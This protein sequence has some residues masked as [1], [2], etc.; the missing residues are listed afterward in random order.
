MRF[1]VLL[2]II[3]LALLLG[4]SEKETKRETISANANFKIQTLSEDGIL[5]MSPSGSHPITKYK[6][7]FNRTYFGYYSSN[8]NIKVQYF[9]NDNYTMSQPVVLWRNWGYNSAGNTLGD[10]HANPSI[11][12]LRQQK[13]E[14]AMHNGKLIV[15]SAE[16]GAAAEKRGRLQVK[17]G[18]SPESISKWEEAI[19]LRNTRATYARLLELSDGTIFLFCRLSR[20]APN[21]RATFFFWHSE[22]AGHSWK[23]KELLVDAN[24]GTDDAIYIVVSPDK[25]GNILHIAA[26]RLDYNNPKDDVWRYRDIYYL[27][28][29]SFSKT[30]S[31]ADS[32]YLGIPPFKLSELDAVW[33][34]ESE[35]EIE[36]WTYI[37][38]IKGTSS[39]PHLVSITDKG[40]GSV[41]ALDGKRPIKIYYHTFRN[42]EWITEEVGQSSRGESSG[43]TYVTMGTLISLNPVCVLGFVSSKNGTMPVIYNRTDLGWSLD[44]RFPVMSKST[45]VHTRPFT[46]G[47]EE[48]GLVGIWSRISEYHGSPYT[49]WQA[50]IIGVIKKK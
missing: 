16:H 17:R 44:N 41:S 24:D 31:G 38:D 9:D 22:D 28:Y 36:D 26:N 23:E 33:V 25:D 46:V 1:N 5:T 30:W 15:A 6:G 14:Y 47:F 2:M 13:G 21:S 35:P 8:H 50:D 27:K 34:S 12:V 43:F 18:V 37:S 3:G 49:D 10:D 4:C 19:Y 32:R 11:L 20:V 45:G 48:T 39:V 42:A 40:R 29:D 7:Q